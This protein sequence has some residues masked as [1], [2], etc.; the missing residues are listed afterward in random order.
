MPSN[1]LPKAYIPAD[2]EDQ[3]Y[4][5]WE[6]SGF[7]NPANLDLDENAPGYSIVMP[8]PNVT[9]TLHMGHAAMLALEDILIRYYRMRG[10]KALWIPGTDHAAIATQTKVEKILKAE[11][12]DRYKLGREEFLKRVERF[13]QESHDTI[14]N[15]VKKM[16][17]SCDWS[18]EAYTLDR[19]RTKAVRTVFKMLYD[20]SLL[21]RGERIVNWC[22]RC[23]STLADDEVEYREQEAKLYYFKYDENFPI[24]IATTRPETKLG[25]T[26]VAVHP[27]DERY[28]KYIGKTFEADFAGI[29]LAI[30]VISD[31]NVDMNFGTGAVGVTPAH[32]Q[33]DW[34]MA[35]EHGLKVVKVIDENGN[36]REGFGDLSGQKAVKAREMIVAKLRQRG[37]IEKEEKI[38]NNL[39]I[40]Y[41]CDTVIEPLPSLQWFI[42][43]DRKIPAYGKSIKQLSVEAVRN[44]V[45]G[46]EKIRIFP[47]RFEKNYFHWMENLRHWCI[48]RQIW[49][50]H[51]IPVW[52]C[53]KWNLDKS[54]KD[55]EFD[56]NKPIVSISE[57]TECPYCGGEVM[58]DNDTL[59][60]W[61]SSGLW[62]FSTMAHD[63]EEVKI[64]D[65]KLVIDSADFKKFHPTQVLETG[66]DILFFWVA[67]MIIMTTYAVGDIPFQH[68]YLHGLVLDEKGKKMSKSKGNVIDPLDMIEK[69]G[70]DA[71]RLSLTIGNA[72]GSDLRLSEERVAGFRNFVNKLWNISRYILSTPAPAETGI[73]AEIDDLTIADHWILD[74]MRALIA[75]VR[76][77]LKNYNFSLAG[78]RLR[79]FTWNHFADW[80][81]E[82]SKFEKGGAKDKI[83]YLIL[84]DLLKLWH[85][86][87]PFVTECLWREFNG[88]RMLLV[89]NYP[90]DKF[91]RDIIGES[92]KGK[93]F[94][95][96]IEIIAAI[97]NARNENRI[98]PARKLKAV[99]YAGAKT[100]L[101]SSQADLIRSLRTGIGEIEIQGAGDK[102]E[103]AIYL[104][105]G[106]V[107]IYL[108][109]GLDPAKEKLRIEK[110]LARLGK[111]ASI[112]RAKVANGEFL[113]K[114]P[115]EIVYQEKRKLDSLELEMAKLRDRLESLS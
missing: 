86:F 98:E 106:G 88:S 27:D 18:R 97:R 7:F 93:S 43:V 59:D 45:F 79:E 19:T 34:Q 60:T 12:I 56:C 41:R 49:Y 104:V 29:P 57:I 105:S 109:G 37:L 115:Q 25:D 2:Y 36:I 42:D 5:N 44:G 48:S 53:K 74:K 108:L 66:Y 69:Y 85:P 23:Q 92:E 80:Y 76:T 95:D 100:D 39:S 50:G 55:L 9:G 47:T 52:Y 81:I 71:T 99:I 46:R 32:S 51:R 63:P 1:E 84:K 113:A 94:K 62:T 90:H 83:L 26:A 68:V 11:G 110:E 77:D 72:P 31:R 35:E 38:K 64:Q 13:A 65:G 112:I 75:G 54:T 22:P 33:A 20:D 102:I 17:S 6:A 21:F 67:R 3:I 91:Y 28:R 87:M 16:G 14:V 111:A 30:L 10:R 82:I 114:A 89:Q 73:A 24:T 96:I 40:C 101:V 78:E 4:K 8:P 58:Q 107:E 15:Q 61:F 103:G 70:T